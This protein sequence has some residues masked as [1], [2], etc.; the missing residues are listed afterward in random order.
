MTRQKTFIA[1]ALAMTLTAACSMTAQS[2]DKAK[3]A[4]YQDGAFRNQEIR[5]E[6]DAA[7]IWRVAKEF[8]KAKRKAATPK[9]P[10]PLRPIPAGELTSAGPDSLYRLGH[11]TMLLRIDNRFVL[12]DPVFSE[13]ASPLVWIGP[14]RFHQ[15]PVAIE[16]LPDNLIIVISHDHYDHLDAKAVKALAPKTDKFLV[17]LRVGY[18]LKRWGIDVAKIVEH[19]WWQETNID[20]I[21]LTATPGQHFSG[22]KVIDKN[23]TLWAGWAIKGQNINVFYSGDTGYFGGFKEIGNRLGPFDVTM[24]ESGAYNNMWSQIH[25]LPDQSVQ[26]HIDL[27]GKAMLPVHNGTFDLALHDW[28]EPF[29]VIHNLAMQRGVTLLTP[30]MGEQVALQEPK[31]YTA[32]WRPMMVEDAET[33]VK[34]AKLSETLQAE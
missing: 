26:A 24:I 1:G 8:W 12:T 16:D 7:S 15:P 31:H 13:R 32:W 10:I 28:Y 25:M 23:H 3:N 34:N 19:D 33:V 20:G 21:A 17:P 27:K 29:E 18:H 30:I 4:I 22:R 9:D 2:E 6:P 14:K 5:Y 11:S